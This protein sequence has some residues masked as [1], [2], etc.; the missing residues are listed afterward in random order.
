MK[1]KRKL[2]FTGHLS[3]R[4]LKILQLIADGFSTAEIGKELSLMPRTVEVY[5]Y[6]ILSTINCDNMPYAI[7]LC[8]RK[9]LIR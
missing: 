9:G 3:E 5:R 4:D 7:A 6:K 8:F 2:T 1:R